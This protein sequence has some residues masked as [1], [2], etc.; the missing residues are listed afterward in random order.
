MVDPKARPL[1]EGI[2]RNRSGAEA[3]GWLTQ[4]P[5]PASPVTVHFN[6]VSIAFT[7]AGRSH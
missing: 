3:D 6:G 2:E 1:T 4:R 5:S 7:A